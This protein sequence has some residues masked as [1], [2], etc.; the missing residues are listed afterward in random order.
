[1][2]AVGSMLLVVEIQATKVAV[3]SGNLSVGETTLQYKPLALIP[4]LR[5]R[6]GSVS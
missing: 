1:M 2:S 5:K 6:Q 4:F 3:V